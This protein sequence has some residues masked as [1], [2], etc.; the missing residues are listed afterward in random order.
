MTSVSI[1]VRYILRII[2]VIRVLREKC[3]KDFPEIKRSWDQL[4][5]FFWLWFLSLG[6][7]IL[8]QY[9]KHEN[10]CLTTFSNTEMRVEHTT[11]SGVFLTN[12]EMF[13]NVVKQCLECLVDFLN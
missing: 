5:S 4:R 12:L 13:G 10:P 1:R 8:K 11:H 7:D 3:L 2:S 6:K 9:S